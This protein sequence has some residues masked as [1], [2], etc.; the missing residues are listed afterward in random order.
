MLALSPFF[1]ND[2]LLIL[3]Q[4]KRINWC[5]ANIEELDY[6]V[7]ELETKK[8]KFYCCIIKRVVSS[9]RDNEVD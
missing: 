3:G 4:E 1:S 9:M 5:E 8:G 7:N 6:R 2:V